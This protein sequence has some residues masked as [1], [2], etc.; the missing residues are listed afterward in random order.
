MPTCSTNLGLNKVSPDPHDPESV[1]RMMMLVNRIADLLAEFALGGRPLRNDRG[2]FI[3]NDAGDLIRIPWVLPPPARDLPGLWVY[4]GWIPPGGIIPWS[5]WTNTVPDTWALCDGTQQTPDLQEHFIRGAGSSAAPGVTGG[6][7]A[8]SHSSHDPPGNHTGPLEHGSLAPHTVVLGHAGLSNHTGS[9]PH[10]ALGSH[11]DHTEH[12][13]D[14]GDSEGFFDALGD[15]PDYNVVA[16]DSDESQVMATKKVDPH[17]HGGAVAEDGNHRHEISYGVGPAVL[18][19]NTEV[20]NHALTHSEHYPSPMTAHELD[21]A[22]SEIPAHA[23]TLEH[24]QIDD[25]VLNLKHSF[26]GSH[27]SEDSRPVFMTLAWIMKLA[28]AG[29]SLPA[30]PFN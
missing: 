7:D 13:H 16:R 5:G 12:F 19:G 29:Q 14:K 24:S 8:H 21:L 17:T 11:P 26:D 25:H 22:H 10:E 28:E 30:G 27:S 15:P 20:E 3:R 23:F 6:A 4:G 2:Q 18:P 1:R 9:L